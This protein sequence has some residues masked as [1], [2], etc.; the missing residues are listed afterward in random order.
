VTAGPT[1]EAQAVAQ[2]LDRARVP[3][4]GVLF[5][6]SAFRRLGAAGFRAEAFIEALLEYMVVGTL[7]MPAMT[8]RVVSPAEPWFDEI[9]TASHVGIL[10]ELFRR[11]Y[12]T[13]RSLHPTHSVAARGRLAAELTAAHHLSD[14]PCALPSPYGKARQTDAHILLLG[15]GLERC[16]AIHHAEEIAAPDIYLFPPEA[17]ETYW[18]RDR[19]GGVHEM[20]LRRHLRLNRDF[21][22]FA[23]PLLRAGLLRQG[24]LCG[25][26]WRAVAQ[27]DLLAEVFAALG[28][29]PRAI[30]APPGAPIIP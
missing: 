18:L 29:D 20:R 8:W 3:G 21:P 13:H 22:Q 23:A 1:R 14:T 11:R 28:R 26:P 25:L 16:T 5:V 17:A 7:V 30:I 24:E 12:A 15:I 10:A 9:E 2:L 19:N 6:H 27:S 4:N